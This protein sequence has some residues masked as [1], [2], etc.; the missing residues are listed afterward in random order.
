MR[1]LLLLFL[2]PPLAAQPAS[3]QQLRLDLQ[4][5][6]RLV[7]VNPGSV[8]DAAPGFVEERPWRLPDELPFAQLQQHKRRGCKN[9]AGSLQCGA[10]WDIWTLA[11]ALIPASSTVLE[12]GARD[13]ATSCVLAR[14]TKNSG[15]VISVEPDAT[16]WKD[17]VANREKNKCNFHIVKGTVSSKSLK[18]TSI[19]S[20]LE[21]EEGV[22][23][24]SYKEV[25]KQVGTKIDT[26]M[27][28]CGG[29]IGDVFD[30]NEGL[31]DQVHL[32]LLEQSGHADYDRWFDQ[33]K[34]K[35][36]QRIWY[37]HD[38]FGE[39]HGLYH[40]AWQRG[41][42]GNKPTCEEYKIRLKLAKPDLDCVPQ[43][44]MEDVAAPTIKAALVPIVKRPVVQASTQSSSA[45]R[46]A[47]TAHHAEIFAGQGSEEAATAFAG[48]TEQLALNDMR[49]A[50]EAAIKFL[51]SENTGQAAQQPLAEIVGNAVASE[52][53]AQHVPAEKAAQL[54]AQLVKQ[55]SGKQ[56]Q[57]EKA[58]ALAALM[59]ALQENLPNELAVTKAAQAAKDAHAANEYDDL[60]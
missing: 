18:V 36:F 60:D 51:S 15:R 26:L 4:A 29:C 32:I 39:E 21:E 34:Q 33:F 14:A 45:L 2:L 22:P 7:T 41:G 43:P 13:G 47:Q 5:L 19:V 20:D 28:H 49:A 52:A 48:R 24:V 11:K 53:A 50:G 58:A 3:Q 10:Q 30:R 37:M 38:T 46:Q 35:G 12:F 8:V 57:A 16:M 1:P 55:A 59:T 56:Q 54:A 25:E 6:E 27:I 23:H 40:S 42:L 9:F 17:L 44:T 31:L